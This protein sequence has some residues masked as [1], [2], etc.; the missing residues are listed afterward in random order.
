M[1]AII[2]I[3]HAGAVFDA[4]LADLALG[5]NEHFVLSFE[6]AD[7]LFADITPARLELLNTLAH[8]GPCSID[9]LIKA[10]G[11]NDANALIDTL[12]LIELGLIAQGDDGRVRV[13]FETLEIRMTL[14]RAA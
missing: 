4:A 9:V 14:A 2:E 6:S 10:T 11:R 13:P 8:L 3:A 5:G 7:T 12:R 1:K